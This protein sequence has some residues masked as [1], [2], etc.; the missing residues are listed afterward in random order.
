MLTNLDKAQ[1]SWGKD[2]PSWVVVFA[3]ACDE[4]NQK[5]VSQKTGYSTTAVNQVISKKY[6]GGNYKNIKKATEG[7]FLS[8][9]VECPILGDL[10]SN[11]CMENQ[12]KPFSSAN[13]Q[14]VR[15]YKACRKC[16]NNQIGR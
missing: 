1:K 12:R 15:L 8:D 7:A 5:I 10:P 6:P 11:N 9:T 4:S 14:R 16:D 3:K 2:I 13:S